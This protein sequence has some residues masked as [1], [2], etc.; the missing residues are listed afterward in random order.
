MSRSLRKLAMNWM[1]T[2][3]SLGADK[4]ARADEVIE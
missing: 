4:L 2:S 3:W 1:T